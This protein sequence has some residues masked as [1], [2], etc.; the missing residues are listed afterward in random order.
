MSPYSFTFLYLFIWSYTPWI[1]SFVSI[2]ARRNGSFSLPPVHISSRA[3]NLKQTMAISNDIYTAI[4]ISKS[5]KVVN[6]FFRF[7]SNKNGFA[8]NSA[9]FAKRVWLSFDNVWCNQFSR[10][11]QWLMDSNEW[12]IIPMLPITFEFLFIYNPQFLID[13]SFYQYFLLYNLVGM[14]FT[15]CAWVKNKEN[16]WFL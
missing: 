6:F 14:I 2:I 10:L 11:W 9:H 15:L 8:D 7:V 12:F 13:V 3:H 1:H 4:L 5:T 16:Q